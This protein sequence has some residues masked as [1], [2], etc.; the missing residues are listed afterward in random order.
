ME[1]C[2]VDVIEETVKQDSN[3]K[4]ATR[5]E[6]LDAQIQARQQFVKPKKRHF[7]ARHIALLQSC[8]LALVN[9]VLAGLLQ[10]V[11]RS[12]LQFCVKVHGDRH[13]FRQCTGFQAS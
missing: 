2:S 6:F 13:D 5:D 9:L 12:V 3:F 8:V 11:H 7:V 4:S 1:I 10:G